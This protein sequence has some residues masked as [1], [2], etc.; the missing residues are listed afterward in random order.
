MNTATPKVGP[1][2]SVMA[3]R[4]A[5]VFFFF[6]HVNMLPCMGMN[7]WTLSSHE[8]I[9][10]MHTFIHVVGDK[11]HF[12]HTFVSKLIW[13]AGGALRTCLSHRKKFPIPFHFLRSKQQP[14]QSKNAGYP[15]NVFKWVCLLIWLPD[16]LNRNSKM[17]R[18][19][20][21]IQENCICLN[22]NKIKQNGDTY[23]IIRVDSVS[24]L[25]K[26]CPWALVNPKELWSKYTRCARSIKNILP[27]LILPV[28]YEYSAR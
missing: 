3:G 18:K 7:I 19:N 9:V 13:I 21:Y 16:L 25:Q 11:E 17:D 23:V 27:H 5:C 20:Y 6:L 28:R 4:F 26:G 10:C 1:F 8:R 15:E 22:L 24:K 12:F 2:I 14:V